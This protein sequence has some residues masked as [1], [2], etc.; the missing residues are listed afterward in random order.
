MQKIKVVYGEVEIKNLE[1]FFEALK[2]NKCE[3]VFINSDYIL[4]LEVI[5]FAAR[6]ALRSWKNGKN[7]AKTLPIEVLLYIAARRQ[8][9][10]ALEIGIKEGLNKVIIVLF[11]DCLDVLEELG[12]IKKRF[13][14]KPDIKKILEFYGI[15]KEEL[16]IV[17]I[18]KLPLLIKER[19]VLFDISK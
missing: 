11:D 3:A 14:P 1:D 4:D 15:N 12:F 5:R 9:N 6:K 18:K 19:I 16:E 2:K 13:I 10:E 7:I 17:G 8:I